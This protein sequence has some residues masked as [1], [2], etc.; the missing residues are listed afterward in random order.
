[1]KNYQLI[2]LGFL[3]GIVN[4][5]LSSVTPILFLLLEAR[6][7]SVTLQNCFFILKSVESLPPDV[8][9]D[10]VMENE[11]FERTIMQLSPTFGTA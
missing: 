1:M 3:L 7:G 2:V 5:C 9:G 8:C 4:T 11:D 10:N 6:F